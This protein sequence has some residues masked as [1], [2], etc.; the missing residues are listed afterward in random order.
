MV[1]QAKPERHSHKG[2]NGELGSFVRTQTPNVGFNG[3]SRRR[4]AEP[5]PPQPHTFHYTGESEITAPRLSKAVP[6][7]PGEIVAG[8]DRRSSHAQVVILDPVQRRACTT[9]LSPPASGST[10]E[11]SCP[12]RVQ[13]L[14]E[15]FSYR[16]YVFGRGD[17][18]RG[19]SHPLSLSK[20]TSSCSILLSAASV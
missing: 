14:R 20:S 5:S 2:V 10:G 1:W 9:E 6:T 17:A 8:E 4:G 13:L 19:A 18:V 12:L 7:R 16:L 11:A 15:P 3:A